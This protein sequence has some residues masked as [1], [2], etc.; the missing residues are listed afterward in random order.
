M[1]GVIGAMDL[2]IEA[3]AKQ[4]DEPLCETVSGV[5]FIRGKLFGKEAVLAVCGIGKVFA[6]LCAETMILRYAPSVIINVG[7]AGALSKE[8]AVGD[9][10][11]GTS[12]VCHDMDTTPI[13]DPLGYISGIGLVNIPLD[14]T[15][16]ARLFDICTSE[17]V[18][19]VRGVIA[20]GDKFIEKR[21]DKDF[22]S[23]TFAASACEMEGQAIAQVCYVNETPCAILRSISDTLE[24]SGSDYNVFKY[25]A[26][27]HAGKVLSAYFKN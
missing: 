7:V 2:E 18:H 24:G 27:E 19:A 20:S 3:L 15:L 17:G 11:V 23:K 12:A 9:M 16:S 5:K 6:A 22:I 4:L 1:I 25:V 10:V 14:E 8:L 13:G 21:S 26:A